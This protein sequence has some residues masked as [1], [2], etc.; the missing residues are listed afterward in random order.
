MQKSSANAREMEQ[1]LYPWR[2]ES[3]VQSSLGLNVTILCLQS[4]YGARSFTTWHFH[5]SSISCASS[6]GE[7]SSHG[8]AIRGA[9]NWVSRKI[10]DWA[11]RWPTAMLANFESSL[12]GHLCSEIFTNKLSVRVI[13]AQIFTSKLSVWVTFAQIF[14]NKLS[15]FR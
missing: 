2:G 9:D 7:L 1:I 5:S 15:V 13:F 4:S 8:S 10:C 6:R 12:R 3:H 14:T 11:R